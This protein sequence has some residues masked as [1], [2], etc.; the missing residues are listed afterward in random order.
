MCLNSRD[1]YSTKRPAPS[2]VT[3]DPTLY[4]RL[5]YSLSFKTL[6]SVGKAT[7]IPDAS[8][9]VVTGNDAE[10]YNPCRK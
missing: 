2:I 4:P 10:G 6:G 1:T 8:C 5:A 3:R 7:I 9:P